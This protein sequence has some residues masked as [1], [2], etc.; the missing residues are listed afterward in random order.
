MTFSALKNEISKIGY[1]AV[2]TNYKFS[3]VFATAAVDR[4]A[5]LAAFTQTPP[6]YRNA[7]LAVV[8]AEN[9]PTA[10][11]VSEFRA[12][13]APLLFVIEGTDVTVW[14]VNQEARPKQLRRVSLDQV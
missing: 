11:I 2:V 3:D 12:L 14:Q 5:A 9:R 8:H 13:G 1:L 7:A 4:T 10:E 6:S